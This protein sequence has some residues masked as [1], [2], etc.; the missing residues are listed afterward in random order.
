MERTG[1]KTRVVIRHL[2]KKTHLS[3]PEASHHELF[4]MDFGRQHATHSANAAS[5]FGLLPKRRNEV[6]LHDGRE[7]S[8]QT[9]TYGASPSECRVIT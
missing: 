4:K 9:L 3:P 1:I 8:L 5:R 6:S 2:S 7:F